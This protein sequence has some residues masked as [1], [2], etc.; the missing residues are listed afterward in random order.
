M[1]NYTLHDPLWF[2]ALALLPLSL[3][4]RGRRRVPVLLVPFAASWHRPSLASASRWPTG[5]AVAGLILVVAGL[6]RPQHIEDK[7][8]VRSEGYDIMLAID[9]SSSMLA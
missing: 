9:L 1:L 5:L 2:L 6:A 8:E 7:R 4:L 3:W